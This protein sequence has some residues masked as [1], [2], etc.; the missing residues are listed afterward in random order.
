M[1]TQ[2]DEGVSA[3]RRVQSITKFSRLRSSDSLGPILPVFLFQVPVCENIVGSFGFQEKSIDLAKI[4]PSNQVV[5]S[6]PKLPGLGSCCL[7]CPCGWVLRL[8]GRVGVLINLGGS[9]S[10]AAPSPLA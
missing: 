10:T 8:T 3:Q 2:C 7:G 9:H 6:R 4:L 5:Y 1:G